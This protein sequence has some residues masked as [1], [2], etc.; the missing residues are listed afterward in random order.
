VLNFQQ[1]KQQEALKKLSSSGVAGAPGAQN[2]MPPKAMAAGGIVAFDNGGRVERLPNESFED[3]KERVLRE[4]QRKKRIQQEK[5][6]E[7]RLR[8]LAERG[9]ALIPPSPLFDRKPLPDT[10][11]TPAPETITPARPPSSG[12]TS[13][14]EEVLGRA[15]PDSAPPI[16][17]PELSNP[18][19]RAA[20][21]AQAQP[22]GPPG[23]P[24]VEAPVPEQMGP[25]RPPEPQA[26]PGPAGIAA[27]PQSTQDVGEAARQASM[28][29]MA[30]DPEAMGRVREQYYEQRMGLT[31]EQRAVYEGGIKDLEKFYA[32]RAAQEK[33]DRIM[34]ALIGAA[35][36]STLGLTGAGFAAG[37]LGAR[38]GAAAERLKG[39]ESL[40]KARTGLVDIERANVQGALGAGAKEREQAGAEARQGLDSGSRLYGYDVNA[41]TERERMAQQAQLKREELGQAGR[42]GERKLDSAALDRDVQNKIR[43]GQVEANR[44][45]AEGFNQYRVAAL[46]GKLQDDYSDYEKGQ[47]AAF[48]SDN[49]ILLTKE[50]SRQRLDSEEETK[51][52]LARAQLQERLNDR[53]REIQ[54]IIG[55]LRSSQ[56]GN[57][58]KWTVNQE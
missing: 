54:A 41:Q 13:E 19:M 39:I 56:I 46:I 38:R 7:E 30:Q 48:Q 5:R 12:M 45:R 14:I 8:R 44:L 47:R 23:A 25:P 58:D 16:G 20:L 1:Q 31:P 28:R 15:G 42:L 21:A 6:E 17:T 34:S 18:R 36:K 57:L 50:G 9:G 49:Q 40:G 43:Q 22:P 27:L 10:S 29:M 51:L 2:V 55:P 52:K 24:P 35:G 32:D 37:D 53:K 33:E 26:P 11:Q 3:Y 4:E